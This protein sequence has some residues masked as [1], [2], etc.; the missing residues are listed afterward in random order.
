[1]NA[2]AALRFEP[3]G[4]VVTIVAG[5]HAQVQVLDVVSE[6]TEV[7]RRLGDIAEHFTEV[8]GSVVYVGELPAAPHDAD[9]AIIL[10]LPDG[11]IKTAGSARIDA[12]GFGTA[13]V[14]ITAQLPDGRIRIRALCSGAITAADFSPSPLREIS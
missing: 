11:R 8:H 5:D 12:S 9:A 13:R 2:H 14:T 3:I 7:V 4:C 6:R 1:M 10:D